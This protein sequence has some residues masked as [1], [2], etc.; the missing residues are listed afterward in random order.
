MLDP[1]R[2]VEF[3]IDF[4]SASTA[5]VQFRF[6]ADSGESDNAAWHLRSPLLR[7]EMPCSRRGA[8]AHGR[9]ARR[10]PDDRESALQRCALRARVVSNRSALP[11]RVEWKMSV[12]PSQETDE[13]PSTAGLFTRGPGLTGVIHGGVRARTRAAPYRGGG[14]APRPHRDGLHPR[15][16]AFPARLGADAHGP[17]SGSGEG[18][19]DGGSSRPRERL[20]GDADARLRTRACRATR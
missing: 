1:R 2:L 14:A 4:R 11:A 13:R 16:P 20:G 18:T 7:V 8:S 3:T 6:S 17:V 12:V 9:S 19:P 5:S 15:T 10:A